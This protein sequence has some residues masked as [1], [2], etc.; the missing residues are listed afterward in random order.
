MARATFDSDEPWAWW[1]PNREWAR[2][3]VEGADAYWRLVLND[4]RERVQL[5]FQGRYESE[6][7]SFPLMGPTHI[8]LVV[9]FFHSWT[10][11]APAEADQVTVVEL[12]EDDEFPETD[13]AHAPDLESRARRVAHVS[14][15]Y[16]LIWDEQNQSFGRHNVSGTADPYLN[17][18]I[19]GLMMVGWTLADGDATNRDLR[20]AIDAFRGRSLDRPALAPLRSELEDM[21]QWPTSRAQERGRAFD[22]FIERLLNAHG[23]DVEKGKFR[24]GEQVDVFVH[25]PFRALVECR[26]EAEPVGAVPITLLIGELNRDRPSIVSGVY[27]SMSGFTEPA[28]E[29]RA[30]MLGIVL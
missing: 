12:W 27:V 28:Y 10:F 6:P 20:T 2:A 22:G 21:R 29:E 1:L 30:L 4:Y 13:L 16:E 26:W 25:R 8:L 7:A 17:R 14:D 19:T 15:E 23:C 3:W 24:T 11:A 18:R 5:Y 9:C